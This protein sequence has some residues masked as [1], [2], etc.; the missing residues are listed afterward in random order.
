MVIITAVAA[1]VGKVELIESVQTDVSDD[2]DRRRLTR[3]TC[4]QKP[5]DQMELGLWR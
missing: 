3:F 2:E 5:A 1:I 4:R